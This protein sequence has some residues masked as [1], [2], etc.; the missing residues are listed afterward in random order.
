LG[1]SYPDAEAIVSG[2]SLVSPDEANFDGMLAALVGTAI[3]EK[4][5]HRELKLL[6]EFRQ[7]RDAGSTRMFANYLRRRGFD[8]P[9]RA[10]EEY[11]LLCCIEGRYAGRIIFPIE[12][13]G[14]LV[15]W[16][17]RHIGSSDLRYMSLSVEEDQ[18]PPARMTI[19]NTLLWYDWLAKLP[20]DVKLVVCEGPFDALKINYLATEYPVYGT[21]VYGKDVSDV[22]VDLLC[23]LPFT[24]KV[25]MF[26]RETI[27]ENL[28]LGARGNITK[29][30][31]L[32][33]RFAYPPPGVKDPGA[34]DIDS[35]SIL[36]GH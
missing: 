17:G 36:F 21:C 13:G 24:D 16:T 9:M 33:F 32:G 15:T 6:P 5:R 14:E 22:Q 28:S 30:N 7:I 10:A 12:M 4:I 3:K 18:I 1:C 29:L 8:D 26:D 34:L 11:G 25:L 2:D 20:E 27:S 23:S 35:F 19:K 31:S